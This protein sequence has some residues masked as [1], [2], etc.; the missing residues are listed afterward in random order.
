MLSVSFLH[1]SSKQKDIKCLPKLLVVLALI[2]SLS[3]FAFYLEE[4][5]DEELNYEL[6]FIQVV[7]VTLPSTINSGLL[8]RFFS[9]QVQLRA[10]EEKIQSI[11]ASMKLSKILEW[12]FTSMLVVNGFTYLFG[13]VIQK[14]KEFGNSDNIRKFEEACRY[15]HIIGQQVYFWFFCF[16]MCKV[17]KQFHLFFRENI[18]FKGYPYHSFNIFLFFYWAIGL[19]NTCVFILKLLDK[20]PEIYC[21]VSDY[22]YSVINQLLQLLITASLYYLADFSNLS[23]RKDYENDSLVRLCQEADNS[24]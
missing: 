2:S 7:L 13:D 23:F 10:E 5:I 24:D 19:N 6:L 3:L 4:M 16:L 22:L 14:I 8:I 12:L 21:K 17:N 11:M 18:K 15:I 9:V 20:V 1:R